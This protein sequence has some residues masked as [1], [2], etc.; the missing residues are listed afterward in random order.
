L[1]SRAL[2]WTLLMTGVF[3]VVACSPGQPLSPASNPGER[4][5]AQGSRVT[6]GV[7]GPLQSGAA[8]AASTL[9]V[10]DAHAVNPDLVSVRVGGTGHSLQLPAGFSVSVLATGL[11]EPRFMAFDASGN[12][13]VGSDDGSVYRLSADGKPTPLLTGLRAPSSLA[14][15]QGYLYV[16]ETTRVQRFL[17][18]SDGSLG[19]PEVIVPDLPPGGHFTR[20]VVFGPDGKLY[21]SV[22][23]SCNIC[24]ERDERRAAILRYD[25]DGSGYQRFAWGVRN[26]VGLAFQPGSGQLWATVNERDD[27]G[28]EIPPDLVTAVHQSDNF[29]WPSCQ[30]PNAT[31][32]SSGADCSGI[33]PPSIGIQAHSAPLGLAFYTGT[34]FPA[35]YQGDLLVVQHGSWNREPPAPPQLLRIHFDNGRAASVRVFAT[36]WQEGDSESR[37]GRP[38]GVTVAPDGS[39]IVSDDTNGTI[40]RISYGGS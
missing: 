1:L 24:D 2:Q 39:L 33:T 40:Y 8:P 23:S 32:Q 38:A 27:Q 28:N 26:A 22:G 13:L 37:W 31:P 18:Q 30:P 25:P 7:S 34:Q 14:F 3:A 21:L 11:S 10:D 5:G 6:T 15:N 19:P 9:L 35:D 12:L 16:A 36:G 17:Y 4:G 29:G 20:T